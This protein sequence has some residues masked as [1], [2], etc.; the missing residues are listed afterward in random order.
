MRLRRWI[1]LAA[2][3]ALVGCQGRRDGAG[4]QKTLTTAQKAAV[5]GGVRKFMA[6]V[7]QDVTKEGPAAWKREFEDTPAF[8]LAS[9][10]RLVFADGKAAAQGIESLTHIVKHI[11]LKWGDDLR[12]DAL[13]PELAVV[14]TSWHEERDDVDGHHVSEGGYFTAVVEQRNG[15][16][17]LRDA[18]WSVAAPPSKV[19]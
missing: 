17:Q 4:E 3:I 13:T 6:N 11:E 2:A 15:Q 10:G 18:H 16:W 14:G 19:P 12:V 7:A 1:L 8:F 5:E 9:E